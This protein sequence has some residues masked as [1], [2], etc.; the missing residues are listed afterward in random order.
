MIVRLTLLFVAFFSTAYGQL[1]LFLG[2]WKNLDPNTSGVTYLNISLRE[3]NRTIMIEAWSKCPGKDCSWGQVEAY[4]YAPSRT[5]SLG[6]IAQTLSTVF[7]TDTT[8]TLMIVRFLGSRL[9]ADVLTHFL[10]PQSGRS[11]FRTV[12]TFAKTTPADT[13]SVPLT[14]ATV[15]SF[16]NW[17][18]RSTAASYLKG[19]QEI[20]KAR[21]D[22]TVLRLLFERLARTRTNDLGTSLITLGIIGEMKNPQATESLYGITQQKSPA[23]VRIIDESLSQRDMLDMLKSKA[24]QG[25]AYMQTAQ[26][27]TLVLRVI[28]Q[29]SSRSVRAT[30]IEAFLFN[31]GD[32]PEA[33][34]Q[35]R[36]YVKP[37]DTPFLD[38]VRKTTSVTAEEF[39]AGIERFYALHP[40]QVPPDSE[41][42]RPSAEK[43]EEVGKLIAYLPFLVVGLVIVLAVIALLLIMRKWINFKKDSSSH[44]KSDK[45]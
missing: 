31:H 41:V 33:K 18:N 40:E 39:D 12:Y 10:A 2:N 3:D 17:A 21:N 5:S 28:Q 19:Q 34:A 13:A 38:R 9:Q 43:V 20:I 42:F 7:R 29:D 14:P 36:P 6:Q 44:D 27:D 37:E 32:S 4:A 30:A 45:R 35:L 25:L 1:N 23:R 24:V 16:I 22:T 8:Q 11:D 26:A 15:D